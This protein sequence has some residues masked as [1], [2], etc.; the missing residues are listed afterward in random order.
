MRT[1][2]ITSSLGTALEAFETGVLGRGDE[3]STNLTGRLQAF[4]EAVLDKGGTLV[5]RISSD[6]ETFT[7]AVESRLGAVEK[8]L[9]EGA[10]TLASRIEERTR[11]AAD[12]MTSHIGGFEARTLK[13]G[14][15][16]ARTLDAIFVR[17]DQEL[18]ARA[19]MLTRRLAGR[20]WRSPSFS[21][22]AARISPRPSRPRPTRP[23]AASQA[24]PKPLP[25]CS[26]PAPKASMQR[27]ATRRPPL[28]RRWMDVSP[29]SRSAWSTA[30]TVSAR[31]WT[32]APAP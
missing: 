23:A 13:S 10:E 17:I 31:R 2:A 19:R 24:A 8:L 11:A 30:S 21:A 6:T 28:P 18:D 7:K 27:L 25:T 14:E 22:L 5:N 3:L 32:S 29:A 15:Q 20:T 9:G 12:A 26:P 1:E 4:E 16:A